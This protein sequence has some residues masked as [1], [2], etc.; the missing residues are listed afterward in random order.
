MIY[1]FKD[2]SDQLV[3][4]A[5]SSVSSETLAK[6]L[7]YQR[8]PKHMIDLVGMQMS[9]TINETVSLTGKSCELMNSFPGSEESWVCN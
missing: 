4:A 6:L 3:E 5:Q 8:R 9:V 1:V 2:H 7:I